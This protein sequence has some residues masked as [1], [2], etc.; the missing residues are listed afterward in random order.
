MSKNGKYL[1]WIKYGQFEKARDKH[2]YEYIKRFRPNSAKGYHGLTTRW[3][4]PLFGQKGT[5]YTF[6]SN[7]KWLWQKFVY[8]NG[9]VA[10]HTRGNIFKDKGKNRIVEGVYPNGKKL[11][12]VFCANGFLGKTREGYPFISKQ[13]ERTEY[14]K[15]RYFHRDIDTM[16]FSQDGNCEY[17]I[18]DKRGRLKYKGKIENRQKTGEWTENYRKFFMLNGLVVP[19]KLFEA[20]AEDLDPKQ[21]LKQSNAQVR[22]MLLKKIGLERVVKECKGKL[23]DKDEKRG[24][25][26]YDFK[27]GTKPIRDRYTPE[28][29]IENEIETFERVLQVKDSSTSQAYFLRIPYDEHFNTCEK[30]RQGTFTGFDIQAKPLEFALET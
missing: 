10:Y 8:P 12:R 4:T 9:R 17:E 14:E 2:E 21:V 11:F 29:E 25:A 5:C 3:D 1:Y 13:D 20:K 30:A 6:Y 7:G 18:W 16:D 15:A 24:N 27:T 19:K 23:I 26:L 28:G 22:A